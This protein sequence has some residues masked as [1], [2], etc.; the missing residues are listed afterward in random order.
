MSYIVF[1]RKW[2]PTTFDEV[3][4][5]EHVTTTLKNAIEQNKVAHA[6]LFCGPRGTGKTTTARILA[7]ALNC[8]KGPTP[9]P[10]NKCNSCKE[11]TDARSLD[12]IEIDA[13]SNRGIDEIRNLREST[14][15]SP[16]SSKYKVYIIDEVH[17]LTPEAFNALLKTLEEPPSHAKFVFATTAAYKVLPTI[18]S[19]CQ[20]FDFKRI[21]SDDI[22]AK[23][24]QIIK[25]EKIK[26]EDP[27]LF[28]IANAA[29]GS[30]RDA[31]TLLDQIN[32]FTKGNITLESVNSVLGLISHD[33]FSEFTEYVI[34]KDT[35]SALRLINKVIESGK[36]GNQFL[37]GFIEYFRNILIIKQGE[38]LQKFI[39]L[40]KEEIEIISKH[41]AEFTVED[42]LYVLYVLIN[43][44][45]SARYAP[46][47]QIP[48]EMLAVKLT[49]RESIVSLAEILKRIAALEKQTTSNPQPEQIQEKPVAPQ[50]QNNQNNANAHSH[51]VDPTTLYKLR[52][53]WPQAI[54]RVRTEKIYAASCLEEADILEFKDNIL[55]LGYAKNNKFHKEILERT[56]TKKLIEGVIS[57]L[58]NTRVAI[59]CVISDKAQPATGFAS[60]DP[61]KDKDKE[62]AQR[63]EATKKDTIKKMLADPIIQSAL[64][65]FDGNIMKLT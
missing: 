25:S 14:K 28:A 29:S 1:A 2:R 24:K 50:P 48:L 21:S 39:D 10:C 34:K 17:M 55:T 58:L 65:I 43:T 4:G 22:I 8:E 62:T 36:D 18:L 19:R 9:N 11:I 16:Q 35:P 53:I 31:E 6:Y 59:E 61:D 57:E 56:P 41:A 13:A 27:A 46:S 52:E 51:Q 12:I 54:K 45:S 49:R 40:P 23:L 26:A 38:A 7:K 20:K 5:Q 30:L 33:T 63:P 64:D 60:Q 37:Q 44:Q 42:I 32:S 3:V 15:F 47:V